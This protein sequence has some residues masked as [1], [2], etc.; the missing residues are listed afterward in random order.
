MVYR[1]SSHLDTSTSKRKPCLAAP[2]TFQEKNNGNTETKSEVCAETEAGREASTRAHKNSIRELRDDQ[3]RAAAL[4]I[5]IALIEGIETHLRILRDTLRK[6]AGLK[7][8]L[9]KVSKAVEP[10]A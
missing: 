8:L 1:P 3:I 6:A 9:L 4:G 5:S 7:P 10:K 2:A